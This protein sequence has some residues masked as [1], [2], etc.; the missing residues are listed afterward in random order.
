MRTETLIP[1]PAK[2]EDNL[3]NAP[4]VAEWRKRR[5]IEE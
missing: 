3:G 5:L 1:L 2:W 4:I